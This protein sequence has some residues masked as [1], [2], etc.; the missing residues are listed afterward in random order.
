MDDRDGVSVKSVLAAWHDYDD[1]DEEDESSKLI[2][3]A[4]VI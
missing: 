2:Y 3:L 4:L 1:D